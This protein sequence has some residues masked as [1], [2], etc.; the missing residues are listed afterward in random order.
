MITNASR[1]YVD[2]KTVT[3]KDRGRMLLD[4]VRELERSQSEMFERSLKYAWLYDRNAKLL[5]AGGK[6]RKMDEGDPT[7]ENIV[8]NN[9]ETATALLGNEQTRVAALTDG[10][11]WS[12]QRRAKRLERFC[13][14]QF[15]APSVDWD[16]RQPR[17]VRS[18]GVSGNGYIKFEIDDGRIAATHVPFDEVIVD[19]EA[20]RA[21]PPTQIAHRRF[22][23]RDVLS[24]KYPDFKAEIE[25]AHKTD[26]SWGSGRRLAP[27]QIVVVEAWHL[28]SKRRIFAI[29]GAVLADVPWRHP[30]FPFVTF[31]WVQ[32]LTG[33]YGCGLAEELASY[34]RAVN[35][36]NANIH[37]SHALFANQRLFVQKND[38]LLTNKWDDDPSKPIPYN[39]KPPVLP[40]WQA[41][42]PEIYAYKDGLKADAQR[43]SG[44]PDMA[45]RSLKPVGLDSGA[46]LREWT[47]IQA[48]RLTTQKA[49]LERIKLRAA[50]IIIALA[51][52]LY[53]KGQDVAAFWNS[54]N[55]AKK[56]KWSE[57]D[58]EEDMYV[59][60]I[61]PASALSRTPAGMRQMMVDLAATGALQPEEILRLW[62]IPDVE[63]SLDVAT[64]A[65]EDIEAEI[66]ELYDGVWRPPEPFMDLRMGIARVGSAYLQARRA[67]A[68]PKI[69]ELLQ[70][71][72]VRA[73]TMLPGNPP[74]S[75]QIATIPYQAGIGAPAGIVGAPPGTGAPGAP[76]PSAAPAA[77]PA[78]A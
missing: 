28:P 53:G 57:V 20:C 5:G 45:A 25:S 32:R 68:P 58:L 31:R 52:E 74:P 22:V 4:Y 64:A 48:S 2:D 15:A 71:W 77:A 73:K 10:A 61:E 35:K 36:T 39:V 17:M 1:W 66:E 56:I 21:G 55:L 18:G 63:R 51:K 69:L 42:K 37:L 49:E 67:G 24:A 50:R 13:E 11:E 54:R 7:T 75:A 29:E 38:L 59:L 41:V 76:P 78:A 44:I 65:I 72:C 3:A 40:N 16:E 70:M 43:Y 6:L 34:Q 12:V 26:P 60:R 8:R 19:D 62:G 23:D 30:F 27:N 9:I 14:A 47:D 46:A 33:F